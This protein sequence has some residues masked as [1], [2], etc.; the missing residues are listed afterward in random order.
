M[1]NYTLIN[2]ANSSPNNII[3]RL[4]NQTSEIFREFNVMDYRNLVDVFHRLRHDASLNGAHADD[5]SEFIDGGIVEIARRYERGEEIHPGTLNIL[6]MAI[7]AHNQAS[8]HPYQ[9]GVEFIEGMSPQTEE[10]MEEIV[11]PTTR[12][13][14]MFALHHAEPW[15]NPVHVAREA[16]RRAAEEAPP[17]ET[18]AVKTLAEFRAMCGDQMD[19]KCP[20]CMEE[21]VEEVGPS[22]ARSGFRSAV[23]MPVVIHKDVDGKWRHPIH[24]TCTH[25]LKKCAICRDKVA[26]PKLIRR[27]SRRPKSSPLRSV[28]RSTSKRSTSKRSTSKRGPGRSPGKRS[29]RSPSIKRRSADF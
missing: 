10:F 13:L 4:G 21:F 5:L 24:M 18:R 19:S 25:E 15:V 6:I 7:Q 20:I 27:L 2:L 22:A 9:F 11:Q 28:K 1:Q 3:R 8:E 23:F 14:Q 16:A 29:P 17:A 12:N 26:Y